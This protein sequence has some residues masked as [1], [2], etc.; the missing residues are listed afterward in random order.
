M[1]LW[2]PVYWLLMLFSNK[3]AVA[4]RL[5]Q[6]SLQGLHH[7]IRAQ[8]HAVIFEFSFQ[9]LNGRDLIY[10]KEKKPSAQDQI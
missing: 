4:Y 8:T 10:V 3:G 9:N 5:W 2:S 6:D 1:I 7:C